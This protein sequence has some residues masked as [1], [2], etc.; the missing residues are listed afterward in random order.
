LLLMHWLCT[1]TSPSK[2]VQATGRT[3]ERYGF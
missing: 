2:A 3:S 1:G